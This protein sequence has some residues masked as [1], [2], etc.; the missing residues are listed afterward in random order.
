MPAT[1]NEFMGH[2]EPRDE[3]CVAQLQAVHPLKQSEL[4]VST[5]RCRLPKRF[6]ATQNAENCLLY[7]S[8]NIVTIS[9]C[10]C[11]ESTRD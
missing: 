3:T 5:V 2:L 4:N 7:S 8:T 11:C 10:K 1:F 9:T 6:I